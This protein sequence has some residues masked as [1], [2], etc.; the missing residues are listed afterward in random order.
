MTCLS[1]A[2]FRAAIG[3]P[4]FCAAAQITPFGFPAL[5]PDCRMFDYEP[6][7]DENEDSTEDAGNEY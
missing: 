1:C 4:D 7:S 6:G 3:E 5:G 2:H